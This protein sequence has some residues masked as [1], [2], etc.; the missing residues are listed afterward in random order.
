MRQPSP[1]RAVLRDLSTVQAAAAALLVALGLVT[2]DSHGG[3]AALRDQWRL[4][5]APDFEVPE[6]WP[7]PV[8][9]F[10][11]NPI[12]R[13]G[14]ALGRRLFFDPVLSRDGSIACAGCHQPFA[15]F[16]HYDHPVSHGIDSRNGRRNAPAL[17][18]LAWLPALMWDGSST[19][20]EL[21]ALAPLENPVEMDARLPEVLARL[22]ADPAWV[23]RVE[24]AFGTPEIDSQRLLRA[25][26][27]FTGTLVSA[28]SRY[29]RHL[30]G[31]RDALDAREQAG[32]AVFRSHC[33]SCHAEP[34]LTDGQFRGNGLDARSA[35][36]GRATVTGQAAD[37]GHFRVPGLRNLSRTPPYMHDGRFD[38]LEQVVAHY[39]SGIRESA[40]LDPLLRSGVAIRDDEAAAL[41]AFLRALDD[42]GFLADPRHGERAALR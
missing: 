37:H 14:Y 27:Q 4:N 36:A 26:A 40:A 30:R 34:L 7:A 23:A 16:A 11:A 3:V 6:G 10:A 17:A 41:L 9:D 12:S 32:L 31:E 22:R 8:Y 24:A 33:A 25:L 5:G 21:Q 1:L 2:L 18:N 29:D 39:R 38:T 15:A 42:P 19:H 13:E 35:D 20:L 28:G